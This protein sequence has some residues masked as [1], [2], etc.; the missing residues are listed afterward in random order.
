M[1]RKIPN[2][3]FTHNMLPRDHLHSALSVQNKVPAMIRESEEP[4]CWKE[5][6]KA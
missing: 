1:G 6:T 3:N 5:D 2:P 4:K